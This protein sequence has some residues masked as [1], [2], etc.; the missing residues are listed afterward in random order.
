MGLVYTNLSLKN[1]RNDALRALEVKALVDSGALMLCIPQHVASQLGLETQEL[2]EA[3]T[4][5][6]TVHKVPYAGPIEVLFED[7][8]C[9]VGALIM[10]DDV[11]L[12]AIPMEDMD[13]IISPAHRKVVVNPNSPNF[14]S[15][16][17][18]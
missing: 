3:T 17:I 10:G 5:D 6:G 13:L 11:L 8:H 1:P 7:R 2:R 14:P 4:A 16:L 18:K 9:Y 12:G 15:A